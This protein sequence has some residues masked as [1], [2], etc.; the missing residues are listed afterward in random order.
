MQPFSLVA[1]AYVKVY[2]WTTGYFATVDSFR[3][4][5]TD[6]ISSNAT[7]GSGC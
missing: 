3:I 5:F 2:F 1:T 7:S 4:G 6:N